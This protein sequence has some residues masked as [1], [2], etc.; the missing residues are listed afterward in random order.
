MSNDVTPAKVRLNDGLGPLPEPHY[1]QWSHSN[2]C[3]AFT[4]GQMRW[5]ADREVARAVTAERK[6]CAGLM[7]SMWNE[8]KA[9]HPS[10]RSDYEEGYLDALDAAEQRLKGPNVAGEA[11]TTA[12]C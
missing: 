5:Y 8:Y 6:R 2:E 12:Q 1:P 3:E 7:D 11:T 9:A 4:G 10:Y